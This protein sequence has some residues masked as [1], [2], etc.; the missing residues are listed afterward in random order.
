MSCDISALKQEIFRNKLHR[1]KDDTCV[2]DVLVYVGL[3]GLSANTSPIIS[4]Q[5][6]NQAQH[7]APL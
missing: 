1:Q 4:R 6:Q 3:I 5:H 2:A 7:H